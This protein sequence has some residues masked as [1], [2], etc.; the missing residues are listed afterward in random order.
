MLKKRRFFNM[1]TGLISA[2]G[3]TAKAEQGFLAQKH[4]KYPLQ[5]V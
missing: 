3:H 4:A 2:D 1:T 5:I